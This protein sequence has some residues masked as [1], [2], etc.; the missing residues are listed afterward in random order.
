MIMVRSPLLGSCHGKALHLYRRC[1]GLKSRTG[2]NLFQALFFTTALV[3]F[4]TT[5]I[6]FIFM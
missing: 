6:A 5:T 3:V 2:L 1:H 4:I